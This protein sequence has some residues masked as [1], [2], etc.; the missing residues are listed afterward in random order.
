MLTFEDAK[1]I[2]IDACAEK[3]GRSFI[4]EY[5]DTSSTGYGDAED[6]AFCYIGV[7]NRKRNI[8]H[9]EEIV[10]DDSNDS[11]W[12]FIAKCNVWYNDGRIEF[13]DCK[14]PEMTTL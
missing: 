3:I 1:K 10:L 2:G 13:F 12:P 14:L 6:H 7:D 8:H 5:A 9:D 4:R 11:K